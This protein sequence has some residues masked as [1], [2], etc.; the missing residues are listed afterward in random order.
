MLN[1]SLCYL[2]TTTLLFASFSYAKKPIQLTFVTEN[3]PPFQMIKEQ[4]I[5]GFATEILN[6]ALTYTPYQVHFK[7]YPW[8]R[9]F[10]LAQK[11]E[12]TCIYSISRT[13]ER[14]DKFQWTQV[15]ATTNANF[16]GL[17]SNKHIKINKLEDAKNYITAVIKDDYTHQLLL[18]NGFKEFKD[19][20]IVNNP[21]SLLK[22]LIERENIDLILVDLLTISYRANSSGIDPELFTSFIQLNTKPLDFYLACSNNTPVEI[23]DNLSYAIDKIKATG[24]Y[25][26]IINKWLGKNNGFN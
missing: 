24:E 14:E 25:Q 1:Q 10:N 4:K 5:T 8:S 22:L 11:K 16:I 6:A 3:L 21:D 20:Y 23:V 26:Q 15:I 9:S 2:F 19:F 7:L 18:N 13:A 17:K 12:N